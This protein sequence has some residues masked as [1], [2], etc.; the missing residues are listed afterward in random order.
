MS[1]NT[2]LSLGADVKNRSLISKRSRILF[3]P[4]IGDLSDIRNFDKF[5]N[6]VLSLIKKIGTK[7]NI[8]VADIHP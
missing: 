6:T 4:E 8:V 5:K 3:G 2:I 1:N 7:P